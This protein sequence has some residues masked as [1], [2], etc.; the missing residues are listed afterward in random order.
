MKQSK[1]NANLH[2]VNLGP[3]LLGLTLFLRAV[4]QPYGI[5]LEILKIL[6]CETIP[7]N[8]N[9]LIVL[10]YIIQNLTNLFTIAFI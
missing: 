3:F 9:I 7:V 5:H 4:Q 1:M 6:K 10:F 8:E 2:L